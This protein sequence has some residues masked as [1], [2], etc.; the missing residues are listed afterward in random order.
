MNER[1][2]DVRTSMAKYPC[3]GPASVRRMPTKRPLSGPLTTLRPPSSMTELV[4]HAIAKTKVDRASRR[5][6]T[7]LREVRALAH[8]DALDQLRDEDVRVG[9]ALPVRVAGQ[10][11][12]YVVDV[13]RE[14]G[15]VVCVEAPD[16]ILVGVASPR[17]LKNDEPRGDL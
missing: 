13:D 10:V 17:V 6:V 5:E 9:V 7:V 11:E 4:S 12:G 16:E 8:L 1:A 3:T 15:A 14:V 2:V